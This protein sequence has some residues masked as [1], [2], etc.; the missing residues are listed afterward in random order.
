MVARPGRIYRRPCESSVQIPGR[1]Q[2]R[3]DIREGLGDMRGTVL[4]KGITLIAVIVAVL[5]VTSG[6]FAAANHYLITDSGQI[7]NGAVSVHDLSKAAR[8]ALK[9]K[10]AAP[11]PQARR[12]FPVRRAR[13]V[14]R[15]PPVRRDR[16]ATSV[17]PARRAPRARRATMVM[18]AR[19]ARRAT[20]ATPGSPGRTPPR[21]TT[22]GDTNAGA[23]RHRRRSDRR[24]QRRCHSGGPCRSLG[25][26]SIRPGR[27]A[28][29]TPV[30]IHSST[31]AA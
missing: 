8:K 4:T 29:T 22:R 31:R 25:L 13:L 17:R 27:T 30:S 3:L 24:D 19:R 2:L 9:G 15:A 7:K 20:R 10:R 26:T 18:R 6:S 5:A 12:G 11:A 1:T 23:T 21:S 28:A 14:R 16:R